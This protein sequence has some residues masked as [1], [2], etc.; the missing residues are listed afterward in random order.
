MAKDKTS[1]IMRMLSRKKLI[2]VL[3]PRVGLEME[4]QAQIMRAAV[5]NG[6][7]TKDV[8][9]AAHLIPKE[10]FAKIRQSYN[11]QVQALKESP[12]G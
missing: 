11:L 3:K 12:L 4:Y 5:A 9:R 8:A 10:L 6:I 2:A 1:T 7:K